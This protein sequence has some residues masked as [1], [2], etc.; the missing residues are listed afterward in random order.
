MVRKRSLLGNKSQALQYI[1][2]E[3]LFIEDGLIGRSSDDAGIRVQH[4]DAMVGPSHAR[5][6]IAMNR[7]CH[8]A[9]GRIPLATAPSPD[10]TYSS[11]VLI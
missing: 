11:L 4:R 3:S 10:S 8:D 1:L 2:A 6:R 9:V 7:F 5:S